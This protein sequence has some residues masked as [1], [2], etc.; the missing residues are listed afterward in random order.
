[1]LITTT[2]TRIERQMPQWLCRKK[3]RMISE[4]KILYAA[5]MAYT[6]IMFQEI[7]NSRAR[8]E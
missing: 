3:N 4:P 7:D 5:S 1:M 2:G 6:K 8:V